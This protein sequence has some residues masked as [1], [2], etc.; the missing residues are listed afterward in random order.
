M[1]RHTRDN[2]GQGSERRAAQGG[3]DK[4][5]IGQVRIEFLALVGVAQADRKLEALR[6][7]EN[8]VGEERPVI[9]GLLVLIVEADAVER[10][11]GEIG[12]AAVGK[13]RAGKDAKAGKGRK[14]AGAG[15][16]KG[17][18]PVRGGVVEAG[19]VTRIDQSLAADNQGWNVQSRAGIDEGRRK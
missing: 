13:A 2:A 1:S 10:L 8:I 5:I 16:R 17:E 9:A 15:D 18:Q 14:D 6:D 7:L 11:P 12:E 4:V 19:R 3:T